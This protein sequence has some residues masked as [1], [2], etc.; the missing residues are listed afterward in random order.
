[1]PEKRPPAAGLI[2]RSVQ[3]RLWLQ[4]QPTYRQ[5]RRCHVYAKVEIVFFVSSHNRIVMSLI[6]AGFGI[7][8]LLAYLDELLHFRGSI[9]REPEFLEF[10]LLKCVVY[11]LCCILKGC[12]EIRSMQKH[13]LYS[14]GPEGIKRL[15]N[16]QINLRRLMV[17]GLATV[18]FRMDGK[19]RGKPNL[20]EAYFRG[21]GSIRSVVTGRV[22]MPVAAAVECIQKGL[23]IF[24]TI[25][26]CNPG[27]LGS[28]AD[29]LLSN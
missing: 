28:I 5:K 11:C 3:G 18:D 2:Q 15:P 24:F 12:L 7:T 22:D 14:G 27:V 4:H 6:H 26:V 21:I 9:I 19:P 1:L 8:L 29:L 17:S 10:A 20:A 16:A 13:G 25:E 23:D